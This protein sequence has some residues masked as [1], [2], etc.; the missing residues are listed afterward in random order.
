MSYG[1][2]FAFN[3]TGGIVWSATVVLI[4]YYAGESFAAVERYVGRVAAIVIAVLVVVGLVVWQVRRRR[5]ESA[6]ASDRSVSS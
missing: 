5:R 6:G 3:A 2:F 1:R 4:G